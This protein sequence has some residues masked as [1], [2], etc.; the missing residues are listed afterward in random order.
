MKLSSIWG[1]KDAMRGIL[2]GSIVA[3][4]FY[5]I[6]PSPDYDLSV[7]YPGNPPYGILWYFLNPFDSTTHLYAYW[8]FA[9]WGS[10]TAFE[11]WVARKGWI[12][13]R[14]VTLQV[15][16]TAILYG[17]HA[18]QNVTVIMFAPLAM[19]SPFIQ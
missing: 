2:L 3:I 15:F 1:E 7:M 5:T 17:L 4:I 19:M 16:T 9:I 13:S 14:L 11:F 8:L 18:Y 6:F 10:V 12:D